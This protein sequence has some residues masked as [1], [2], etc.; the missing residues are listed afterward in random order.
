MVIPLYLDFGKGWTRL[1]SAT[2]QGNSSVDVNVKLPSVPK[3]TAIAALNDVLVM[4][5]QNNK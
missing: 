4:S 1:G 5:I 3:R 2:L